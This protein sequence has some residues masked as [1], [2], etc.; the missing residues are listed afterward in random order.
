[1]SP[2][3]RL[4][5]RWGRVLSSRPS[6]LSSARGFPE[7][8]KGLGR[9]IIEFKSAGLRASARTTRV[10]ERPKVP[11][12]SRSWRKVGRREGRVQIGPVHGQA[13]E[14]PKARFDT[15]HGQSRGRIASGRVEAD[16]R[17]SAAKILQ[18]TEKRPKDGA[19]YWARPGRTGPTETQGTPK[20]G[21]P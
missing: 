6:G 8:G 21:G 18:A 13:G 3:D 16:K 10:D 19:S 9:S 17:G 4:G 15:V 12:D 7:I 5:L 2:H 11:A 14:S 1:M 20:T